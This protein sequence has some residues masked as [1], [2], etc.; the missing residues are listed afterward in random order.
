[1][2]INVEQETMQEEIVESFLAL[3][4]KRALIVVG[5]GGGKTKIA[6][7]IIKRLNPKKL[8]FLSESTLSRDV[9]IPAEMR[10]WGLGHLVST[11][12]FET[13]QKVY[14]WD[15][16]VESLDEY[17]VIADEID[18]AMTDSYGNFFK[19]YSDVMTLGMTG[20]IPGNK[21]K[22]YQALLPL[23]VNISRS[24][25][26]ERKIV[27]KS[28]FVFVQ[29]C[30]SKVRNI[31]VS[32]KKDGTIK[33]F[34]Q[35]E[36]NMYDHITKKMGEFT[37]NMMIAESKDDFR[38][39]SFCEFMLYK[40]L[41]AERLDLL[42]NLQSSVEISKQIKKDV[43]SKEGTK[44]VTFSQRTAQADRLS[45]HTYHGKNSEAVNDLNYAN[46]N[47]GK[48]RDLA[49][50]QK[51]NRSA[52]MVGLTHAVLESYLTDDVAINQ[53]NGRMLRLTVD[54]VSTIYILLPYYI[55][56]SEGGDYT[57]APTQAVVWARNMMKEFNLSKEDYTIVNYCGLKIEK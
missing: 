53:R 39:I 57:M 28:K 10:K 21:L 52:N 54:E 18:F 33:I 32:Y 4:V 56:T 41:P 31:P 49:L 25:L 12:R 20:Y 37:S 38:T 45:N 47:Y 2:E 11:A 16:T 24:E 22:E 29:F 35:S 7:T 55:K 15:K 3:P 17:L 40:K 43:L 19:N 14:K 26:Q 1:M 46:F 48:T 44:I 34:M 5:T 30:L 6:M 42:L 50:C 27:N 51:I 13:Y 8:L 23:L 9:T 36:N